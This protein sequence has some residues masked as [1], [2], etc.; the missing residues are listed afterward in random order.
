MDAV[1][2]RSMADLIN[3]KVDQYGDKVF[4]MYE[5]DAGKYEEYT[6]RQFDDRINRL[7]NALMD[8]GVKRGDKVTLMLTNC[9]EFLLAWFAVNKVGA[10]MVPGNIF[11]AADELEYMLNFSDS[12]AFIT[13]PVFLPLYEKIAG[14]TPGVKTFILAKAGMDYLPLP[15]RN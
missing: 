13:E 10:V 12:V 3:E 4:L 15:L 11:Y 5:S 7:A 8:L 6:Y 14:K 2:N 9:P 1:G